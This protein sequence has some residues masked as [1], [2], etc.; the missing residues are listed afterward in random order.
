M[1]TCTFLWSEG[2]VKTDKVPERR[3]GADPPHV[4]PIAYDGHMNKELRELVK[5]L[6]AQ[7][8][9]VKI[10]KKNHYFVT[11]DGKPVATIA[12]TPSDARSMRNAR[13]ALRRAGFTEKK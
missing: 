5:L 2:W 9:D 13:A 7:G 4:G 1:G 8:F 3:E 11:K 6:Q 10:T 12:G